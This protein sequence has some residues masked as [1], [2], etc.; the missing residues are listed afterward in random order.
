MQR[1]AVYLTSCGDV[2]RTNRSHTLPLSLSRGHQ[3]TLRVEFY[4]PSRNSWPEA[5]TSPSRVRA[6]RPTSEA[7]RKS[8]SRVQLA[9]EACDSNA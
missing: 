4:R 9:R 7:R 2:D 6:E 1:L 8:K 5:S 3:V